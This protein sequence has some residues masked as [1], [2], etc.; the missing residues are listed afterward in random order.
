VP[1]IRA[2]DGPWHA[3]A[4][5]GDVSHDAGATGILPRRHA[6][7]RLQRRGGFLA[8]P[9]RKRED[10]DVPEPALVDVEAR[11]AHAIA[12]HKA[13]LVDSELDPQLDQLVDRRE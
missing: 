7:G 5:P 13:E 12:E 1:R 8:S 9:A 2:T 4:A 6:P 3:T 10:A 11:V